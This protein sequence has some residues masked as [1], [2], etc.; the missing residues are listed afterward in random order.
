MF[1]LEFNIIFGVV[2]QLD[3]TQNCIYVP[4]II[5]FLETHHSLQLLKTT[6]RPYIDDAKDRGF[7]GN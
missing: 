2:I 7:D 1:C 6:Q 4:F 3:Y 5:V